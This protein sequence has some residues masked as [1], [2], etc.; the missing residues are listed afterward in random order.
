M[1]YKLRKALVMVVIFA[2]FTTTF[3]KFIMG[4]SSSASTDMRVNERK[5]FKSYVV[6][7]VDILWSIAECYMTD[8]YDSYES[9]IDEVID[10]NHLGSDY[11]R[12]G[13]LIVIP[14]YSDSP[15]VCSSTR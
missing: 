13:Q 2:V 15:E 9:Y 7:K 1:N 6:Q 11:L 3:M 8:E 12:E 4:T 14:Y 5:Y 10:S